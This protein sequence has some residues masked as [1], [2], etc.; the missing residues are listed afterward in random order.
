METGS[1]GECAANLRAHASAVGD[2]ISGQEFGAFEVLS[3]ALDFNY[4]RTLNEARRLQAELAGGDGSPEAQAVDEH[5]D[6][7]V[8]VLALFGPT[9]EHIKTL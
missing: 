1:A 5:V 2:D 4:S 8:A 7:I 9:R 3:A 6:G